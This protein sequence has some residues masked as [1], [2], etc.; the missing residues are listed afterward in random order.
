MT[1]P[2]AG[3]FQI[4]RGRRDELMKRYPGLLHIWSTGSIGDAEWRLCF[5]LR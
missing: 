3:I 4:P 2:S 5:A 1:Q